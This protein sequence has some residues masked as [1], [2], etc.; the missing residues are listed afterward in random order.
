MNIGQIAVILSVAIYFILFCLGAYAKKPNLNPFWR[1]LKLV[2]IPGIFPF[3]IFVYGYLHLFPGLLSSIIWQASWSLFPAY[4]VTI[5]VLM[6]FNL[7]LLKFHPELTITVA[8]E[9]DRRQI[10][11]DQ[12]R[13]GQAIVI[14]AATSLKAGVLE[15]ILFR[16]FGF[17]V[18]LTLIVVVKGLTTLSLGALI[19]LLPAWLSLGMSHILPANIFGALF[20]S[21]LIFALI[22]L[23]DSNAK[24]EIRSVHKPIVAWILGWTLTFVYLKY[25][26]LE[27]I[28]FHF[29]ADFILFTPLFIVRFDQI[30]EKYWTERFGPV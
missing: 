8:K 27:A 17:V 18:F 15:E 5:V 23:F 24:I 1:I 29:L 16:F 21:N 9:A 14:A 20:I 26:I 30:A 11:R 10:A 4:W 6:L 7:W 3:T 2:I 25:G 13:T 28:F 12:N 22:H 19:L